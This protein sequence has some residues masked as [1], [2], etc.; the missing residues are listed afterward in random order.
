MKASMGP[1]F[2]RGGE[3][4]KML[5][6]LWVFQPASMGPPFLRGG[7]QVISNLKDLLIHRGFNGAALFIGRRESKTASFTLID[8]LPTELLQWGRPFYRAESYREYCGE[9]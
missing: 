6:V 9:R 2:L 3:S 5:V 1:P 8:F 4:F 7:E